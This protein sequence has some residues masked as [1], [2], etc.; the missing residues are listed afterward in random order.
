LTSSPDLKCG[1]FAQPSRLDGRRAE[2]RFT[3]HRPPYGEVSLCWY[4]PSGGDV[5]CGVHVGV[6]WPRVA[7]NA[8]ENRLALA[9]FGC[10]VPT[11]RTSLRR[12]R[13]YYPFES[14]R[15][16]VVKPDNQSTPCLTS[17]CSVES[18]FLG[19]SNTGL[20]ASRTCRTGHRPHVEVLDSDGV[21]LAREV[22]GCLLD[23]VASPVG[24]A[25]PNF[26]DR[27]LDARSAVGSALSARK[28]LLKP[29]QPNRL[30]WCQARGVQQ[31]PG[32]Q[33]SRNRHTTIDTDHTAIT[34]AG[35]R[36]GNMR[37]RNMPAA[38]PIASDAIRLHPGRHRSCASKSHP[39]NLGHPHAAVASIEVFDM[40]WFHPDLPKAFMHTDLAPRWEA[41]ASCEKV[42]HGLIEVPQSLLLYGLRPGRQP[43][44]SGTN[45]RQLGRLFAVSRRAATRLPK[46][47]LLNGQIPHKAGMPTMFQ[48]RDLL[49][50][51]RQQAE[52]DHSR[53]V[54]V[55][56][57]IGGRQ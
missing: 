32:R 18:A 13:S 34:R 45:L 24:F 54:T 28:A 25:R 10:D 43:I 56:T 14:A 8:R 22:G 37:E 26:R 9:V 3:V 47:L 31:L 48:K 55:D 38:S 53:N 39:P 20:L 44:V 51:C 57:D 7:G 2:F 15:S 52:P 5:A 12:V 6:A 46:S 33:C 49:S 29:A 41:M 42:A 1:D 27:Q 16:L 36:F 11:G 40:R 35:Y 21:E 30:T 17:D 19:D 50:G 23:P 4:R